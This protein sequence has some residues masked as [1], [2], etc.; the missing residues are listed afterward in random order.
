M[1]GVRRPRRPRKAR[2]PRGVANRQSTV[3]AVGGGELVQAAE[4]IAD[5]ARRNAATWA[6][7]GAVVASIH[8]EQSSE[9]SVLIVADAPA[10]YPAETRARHPLFG[11]REYWYGPPGHAFLGPA[12]DERAGAAL[13]KYAKKVDRLAKAAG[14]SES[15]A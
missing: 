8:T 4:E 12:A 11:N 14:F 3:G 7:T 5:G 9:A 6:K 2:E 15:R 13:A 10:A 1:S